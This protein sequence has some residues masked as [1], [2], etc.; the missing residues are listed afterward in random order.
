MDGDN[1]ITAPDLD[2][3]EVSLFGPGYG[4]C[5]LLH[6]GNNEWFIVDS[7]IDPISREPVSLSYLQQIGIDPSIAVKQVIVSHWHDDHYRGIA[8]VV[9]ACSSADFICSESSSISD[10]SDPIDSSNF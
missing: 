6:V 1:F 4:E 7:C 10:S 9:E 3:I 8:K 5:I 2:E